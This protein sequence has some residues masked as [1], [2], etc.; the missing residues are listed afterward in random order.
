ML[1]HKGSPGM[2][3]HPPAVGATGLTA[4]GPNELPAAKGVS[5]KKANCAKIVGREGAWRHKVL[6]MR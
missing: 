6:L 4:G 1:D 3:R 5:A 2:K